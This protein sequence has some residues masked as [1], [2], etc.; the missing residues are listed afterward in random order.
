[1]LIPVSLVLFALPILVDRL[2]TVV[3]FPIFYFFGSYFLLL[4][5][6]CVV[7]KLHSRPVYY[8]DLRIVDQIHDTTTF[9]RIYTV[10][11]NFLLALIFCAVADYL[12]IQ[13][14][15]DMSLAEIISLIGGNIA[16]FASA[17]NV[18]GKVIGRLCYNLKDNE[19]V[20]EIVSPSIHINYVRR[21]PVLEMKTDNT[22][23]VG[24]VDVYVV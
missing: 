10:T 7:E 24:E 4:N 22:P 21:N 15:H 19:T 20:L 11:M 1:V 13:G 3:Y 2:Y 8:E 5:F 16:A 14:I 6:P 12:V 23:S 18:A 17:Q 9:Q